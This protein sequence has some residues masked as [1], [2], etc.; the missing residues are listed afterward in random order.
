MQPDRDELILAKTIERKRRELA[1][2]KAEEDLKD[3]V[4]IK[5]EYWLDDETDAFLKAAARELFEKYPDLPLKRK[6]RVIEM[7]SDEVEKLPDRNIKRVV[8]DLVN[9]SIDYD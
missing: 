2:R 1:R 6:E 7:L 3:I 9:R 8:R 5:K 4:P